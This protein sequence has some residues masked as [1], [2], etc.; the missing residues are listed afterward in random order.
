MQST[1]K[2]GVLAPHQLEQI[3]VRFACDSG[4]ATTEQAVSEDG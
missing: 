2:S 1:P 3:V 4:I